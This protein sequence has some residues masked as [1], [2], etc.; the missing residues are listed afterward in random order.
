LEQSEQRQPALL[1]RAG[2]GPQLSADRER[3]LA[4]RRVRARGLEEQ[5]E[6]AKIEFVAAFSQRPGRHADGRGETLAEAAEAAVADIV[7]NF[8][9]MRL[10][11]DDARARRLDTQRGEKSDRCQTGRRAEQAVEMP[12]AAA[13]YVGE[14]GERDRLCHVV[15]EVRYHPLDPARI[16]Q[17]GWQD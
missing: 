4:L 17:R 2:R 7:G 8:D 11:G 6:A 3:R 9:D 10:R 13:R 12:R 5:T 15:L 14:L 1:E 16:V